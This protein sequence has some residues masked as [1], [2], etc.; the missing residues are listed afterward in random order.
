[1]P[2]FILNLPPCYEN[3]GL[4]RNR[5]ILN[6]GGL[7]KVSHRALDVS[8][9]EQNA[10]DDNIVYLLIPTAL[11]RRNNS[12]DKLRVYSGHVEPAVMGIDENRQLWSVSAVMSFFGITEALCNKSPTLKFCLS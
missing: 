4:V 1:M 2:H 3:S 7:C 12:P 6:C 10:S 9:N 5:S 8:E 11:E